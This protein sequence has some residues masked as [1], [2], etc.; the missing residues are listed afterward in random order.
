MYVKDARQLAGISVRK[1]NALFFYQLVQMALI[2][3]KV[4]RSGTHFL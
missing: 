4:E 3:P 1:I 2:P